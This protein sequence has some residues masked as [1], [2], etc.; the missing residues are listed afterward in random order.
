M[1]KRNLDGMTNTT[2]K[3]L[4]LAAAGQLALAAGAG[5]AG[6]GTLYSWETEDGTVAYADD[7]KRV[8][9]RYRAT[10]EK[11]QSESLDGYARYTPQP[12]AA[13]AEYA[14]RLSARLDHL[15][16]LNAPAAAPNGSAAAAGQSRILLQTGSSAVPAIEVPSGDAAG[17]VVVETKR[18]KAKGRI[19][20][21]HNTTVS[22]DGKLVAV[23]K[24]RQRG[25]ANVS[26]DIRSEADLP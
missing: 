9:E 1:R 22:Q 17:P 14:A 10:A 12:A 23:I 21:R 26:R 5:V 19:V 20:T 4:A 24:Q 7:W 3:A 15:A 8:P 16:K 18:Y 6:A 2:M 13:S 25:E 11:R